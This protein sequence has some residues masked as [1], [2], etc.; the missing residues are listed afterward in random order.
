M[1]RVVDGLAL[2]L[3]AAAVVI[4][5]VRRWRRHRAAVDAAAQARRL[6]AVALL[7]DSGT[8]T[9]RRDIAG[10]TPRVSDRRAWRWRRG[11]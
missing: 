2:G 11:S 4:E 3:T 9:R 6:R 5:I 1:D 10:P 8:L 7:Q